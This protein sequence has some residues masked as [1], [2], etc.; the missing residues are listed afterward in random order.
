VPHRHTGRPARRSPAHQRRAEPAPTK[1]LSPSAP[2]HRESP[3]ARRGPPVRSFLLN[4]DHVGCCVARTAA[5]PAENPPRLELGA[6]AFPVPCWRT[7]GIDLLLRHREGR[8]DRWRGRVGGT[9]GPESL[10]H[11]PGRWWPVRLPTAPA[12]QALSPH[13]FSQQ[14]RLIRASPSMT[15][16]TA[17]SASGRLRMIS[18]VGARLG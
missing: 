3:P 7:G 2:R 16:C 13:P 11:P 6:R 9:L 5:G 17:C 15:T 14:T 4:L 18:A 12:D 10:V 8:D 1:Q